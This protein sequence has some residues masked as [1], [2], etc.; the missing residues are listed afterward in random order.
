MGKRNIVLGALLLLAGTASAVTTKD[1]ATGGVSA[2]DL[3]KTLTGTGVTITNVKVTGAPSAIGTF[4][5]GSADGLDID[6]GVLMSSGNISTAAGPNT[7]SGTT[8]PM[9]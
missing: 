8:L 2:D 9:G 1:M 5:G 4:T 7:S 3:V 6:S